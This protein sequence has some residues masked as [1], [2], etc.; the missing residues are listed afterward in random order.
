MKVLTILN[1]LTIG[2]IENTLYS[3]LP[4]L[5]AENIKITICCLEKDAIL[6]ED[7]I[8]SGVEII[9]IKKTGSLAYDF[10]QLYRI[11]KNNS[12]DL[13][14]SRMSYTSGGFALASKVSKTPFVLSIHNEFAATLITWSKKFILSSLRSIYLSIHKLLSLKYSSLILG[15]SKSNLDRNYPNWKNDLSKYKILYN[16]VDFK[17]LDNKIKHLDNKINKFYKQLGDDSFVFIHT[18]TFKEQKNHIFMIECFSALDPIQNNY[19]LILLGDG[20]LR[21]II[22][23]KIEE[24]DL[25]NNVHLIGFTKN[26]GGWLSKADVFY[27]PSLFEG[28]ANVIIEAQYCN[29][30]ICASSIKP[31]YESVHVKYHKYMYDPNDKT[32]SVNKMKQIINDINAGVIKEDLD[33]INKDIS[34]NFSIE[35]MSS[36]LAK[37]YNSFS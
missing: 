8:E 18:G 12:F 22:E 5:K 10:I 28:F 7:F 20:E 15:H 17:A 14:H 30:P 25:K 13:V 35:N 11:L 29:L 24:K 1:S 37:V 26:V 4:G 36:N 33:Q 31:H 6:E 3:C 34:S 9:Y 2:G 32:E 19:H 16:G 23:N 27:F 21:K